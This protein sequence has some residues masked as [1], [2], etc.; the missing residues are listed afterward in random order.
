[1]F[2]LFLAAALKNAHCDF[3]LTEALSSTQVFLWIL[4]TLSLSRFL[5]FANSVFMNVKL[6]WNVLLGAILG[7]V[8]MVYLKLARYVTGLPE[9]MG[10]SL[11][12]CEKNPTLCTLCCVEMR[13]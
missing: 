1:M 4:K 2:I 3:L 8:R 12:D 9:S 11:N 6:L 10:S 7:A 5:L 13:I